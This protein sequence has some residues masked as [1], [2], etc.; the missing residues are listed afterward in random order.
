MTFLVGY[1]SHSIHCEQMVSL[2]TCPGWNLSV[3]I[4]R[5]LRPGDGSFRM[6]ISRNVAPCPFYSG[7]LDTVL[8]RGETPFRDWWTGR[9]KKYDAS[10]GLRVLTS[11]TRP[12]GLQI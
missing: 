11:M 12:G 7:G 5:Y 9:G 8:I 1:L 2:Q 4:S 10:R 3:V 6:S